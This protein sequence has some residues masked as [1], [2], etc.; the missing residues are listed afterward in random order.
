MTVTTQLFRIKARPADSGGSRFMNSRQWPGVAALNRL[1]QGG[2]VKLGAALL[3]LILAISASF[4]LAKEITLYDAGGE[5]GAYIATDD[6]LT[7]YLREGKP[8]AYLS[9]GS[10]WGFNGKH[11]GWFEDGI[12]WDHKG[13]AA[14]CVKEAVASV[15]A[16]EPLKGLKGLKPLKSLKELPPLRPL[17]TMKWSSVPLVLFLSSGV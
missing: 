17:K 4:A 15:N 3:L 16:L 9:E 12:I 11:L 5:P 6:D 14:G 8:V 10:V 7:I 13:N 2:N 1:A